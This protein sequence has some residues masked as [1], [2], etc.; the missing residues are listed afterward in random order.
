LEWVV[1]VCE[2]GRGRESEGGPS[3]RAGPVRAAPRRSRRNTLSLL[4]LTLSWPPT[5][6]T[7]NEMFLY[8]TVST[9]KPALGEGGRGGWDEKREKKRS[10]NCRCLPIGAPPPR[11]LLFPHSPMVGMVVT[12]SPSFSLYRMV[13]LPAAS[14]PT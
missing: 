13:V 8:S 4:S 7:V 14:R 5:S 3:S 2:G 9:L 1:V 6:H 12:I 10:K 11:A